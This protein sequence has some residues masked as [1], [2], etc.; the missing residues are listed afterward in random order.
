MT[1]TGE[2]QQL[3]W[4]GLEDSRR[5]RAVGSHL[6]AVGD[7][8]AEREY[9]G[10]VVASSANCDVGPRGNFLIFSIAAGCVLLYLESPLARGARRCETD[11]GRPFSAMARGVVRVVL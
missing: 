11:R 9:I 8:G 1:M 7:G 4:L 3:E 5:R 6:R 2:A 10:G